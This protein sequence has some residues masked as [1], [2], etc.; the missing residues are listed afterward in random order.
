MQAEAQKKDEE[1]ERL[2]QQISKKVKDVN[3]AE[4]KEKERL[5]Q[6]YSFKMVEEAENIKN[7][8]EK[9]Q[10]YELWSDDGGALYCIVNGTLQAS[11]IG[12]LDA[13]PLRQFAPGR[14]SSKTAPAHILKRNVQEAN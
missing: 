5:L 6:L 13:S 11:L 7:N 9:G 2:A 3:L 12:L 1:C 4:A 14:F 10:C 8:T